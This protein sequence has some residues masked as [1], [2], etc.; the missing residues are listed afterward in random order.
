MNP[1]TFTPQII[2][3]PLTLA[4][5]MILVACQGRPAFVA[6]APPPSVA[7]PLAQAKDA[8]TQAKAQVQSI[9]TDAPALKTDAPGNPAVAARA[10]AIGAKAADAASQIEVVRASGGQ[11]AAGIVQRDHALADLQHQADEL[12]KE[13]DQAIA[14]RDSFAR[15]L[16][17]IILSSCSGLAFV[18]GMVV[19]YLLFRK[20]SVLR[21]IGTIAGGLVLG[22]ALASIAIKLTMWMWIGGIALVVVVA[23]GAVV[24]ILHKN[25]HATT[26]SPAST[27]GG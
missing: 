17:I 16:I 19:G 1:L 23:G 25:K 6:P 11:V 10:D 15:R 4:F 12:A 18:G 9:Q 20:G 21:A 7:A 5:A 22:G 2:R 13:R 27:N 26:V 24:A 8:L 3:H 14:D